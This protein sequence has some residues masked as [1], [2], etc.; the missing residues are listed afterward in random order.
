M[1]RKWKKRI[2]GAISLLM[3]AILLPTMLLSGLMVDLSRYNMAKAMISSAG[4][5][6]MNAALADYDGILQDVY[7]L[8]AVSQTD[9][10]LFNNLSKYFQTTLVSKGVVSEADSEDYVKTLLDNVFS[11]MALGENN[12]AKITNLFDMEVKTDSPVSGAAGSTLENPNILKK[13]IVEYMKYRAPINCAM[14][15]FSGLSALTKSDKQADVVEAKV[16]A[17]TAVREV[18]KGANSLWKAIK[19]YDENLFKS[20]TYTV[21]YEDEK[22]AGVEWVQ[23]DRKYTE[24]T[25]LNDTKDFKELVNGEVLSSVKDGQ[26]T[27]YNFQIINRFVLGFLLDTVQEDPTN[28]GAVYYVDESNPAYCSTISVTDSCDV[29]CDKLVSDAGAF[30]EQYNLLNAEEISGATGLIYQINQFKAAQLGTTNLMYSPEQETVKAQ[31]REK[32]KGGLS[33]DCLNT[34]KKS[35]QFIK[36]ANQDGSTFKTMV[37]RYSDLLKKKCIMTDSYNKILNRLASVNEEIRKINEEDIPAL[38]NEKYTLENTTIPDLEEQIEAAESSEDDETSEDTESDETSEEDE[39]DESSEDEVDVEALKTALTN[40]KNRVDAIENTDIPNLVNKRDNDLTPKKNA[41]EAALAEAR[42]ALTGTGSTYNESTAKFTES[43]LQQKTQVALDNITMIYRYYTYFVNASKEVATKL[44]NG[45]YAE[46]KYLKEKVVRLNSNLLTLTAHINGGNLTNEDGSTGSSVKGLKKQIEEYDAKLTTWENANKKVAGADQSDQFADSMA[47]EIAANREAFKWEEVEKV[48]NFVLDQWHAIGPLCN[49]MTNTKSDGY[50]YGDKFFWEVNSLD[51]AISVAKA[52]STT[53]S[54]IDKDTV[55]LAELDAQFKNLN[56]DAKQGY[57]YKETDT[58]LKSFTKEKKADGTSDMLPFV[59]YLKS[60]YPESD[61]EVPAEDKTLTTKEGEKNAK[62]MYEDTKKTMGEDQGKNNKS[63][64]TNGESGGGDSDYYQYTFKGEIPLPTSQ[65]KESEI[66]TKVDVGDEE[67]DTSGKEKDAY[68]AKK[69]AAASLLSGIAD[70]METGRDNLFVMEYAFQNFSYN[71]IVQDAAYK[72]STNKE[73]FYADYLG[74]DDAKR[75]EFYAPYRALTTEEKG[76]KTDDPDKATR[77]QTLSGYPISEYNN[78]FYGAEVEYLVFGLKGSENNVKAADAS[79]FAI[80]FVLNSIF[81]FTNSE[82]RNITRTAGLAVQAASLG[83]I[84]Y[85]VVMVVLQLALTLSESLLDIDVMHTGAK[86]AIVPT[87]DTWMLSPTGAGN[88][89]KAV[90]QSK[91]KSAVESVVDDTLTMVS[92]GIQNFVDCTA[93]QMETTVNDLA[94]NLNETAKAKA[95]ELLDDTLAQLEEKMISELN[96]LRYIEQEAGKAAETQLK[97]AMNSVFSKVLNE[98]NTV[99]ASVS[100]NGGAIGAAIK[101]ILSGQIDGLLTEL[102]TKADSIITSVVSVDP[103]KSIEEYA[104]SVINKV[105]S[106]LSET[107]ALKVDTI[108]KNI[109]DSAIAAIQ[110]ECDEIKELA[111]DKTEEAKKKIID[112]TNKLIDEKINSV[113]DKLPD[114]QGLSTSFDTVDGSGAASRTISFGYS[115]Y[116]RVFFFL[117]MCNDTNAQN[118]MKRMGA[119]IECN[120]NYP[121]QK[122]A[123]VAASKGFLKDLFDSISWFFSKKKA[124][125]AEGAP[126]ADD[127]WHINKSYTYVQID[128]DIDMKMFFLDTPLFKNAMNSAFPEDNLDTSLT[129]TSYH[130]HGVMGY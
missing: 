51:T 99:L 92:Q 13:Q 80:R 32:M 106:S 15:F 22:K 46:C 47:K 81:A 123:E 69:S 42:N 49:Y 36:D 101:D 6:T 38:N 129:T 93:D 87:K 74:K 61:S 54:F 31:V 130:Y 21:P 85:Q 53:A 67:S 58:T 39:D 33:D 89:L 8:F 55:T 73:A 3:V 26:N 45:T 126:A 128:A 110:S 98:K 107:I 105:Q 94:N 112:K 109:S 127:K 29:A 65:G 77:P 56:N 90:A 11:Y 5:L 125:P 120:I 76:T 116:L 10:D 68:N 82:I 124:A 44:T 70:A 83:I 111:K 66:D 34:Y 4:D 117:A 30:Y 102:H 108:M 86:V 113:T 75:K 72:N 95:N 118:L 23:E 18:S 64:G 50:N 103:T 84:P 119:L 43:D 115:D 88:M 48:Y 60:T 63:S 2:D 17:E 79:I 62:D 121:N 16:D 28:G 35:F 27:V 100:T 96:K 97:E 25:E 52:V 1:K 12:E 71:T 14:S 59:G 41:Y 37:T 57:S 122:V 40:A 9:D 24:S 19:K 78:Q 20:T 7:G 104:T 91:V 114:M